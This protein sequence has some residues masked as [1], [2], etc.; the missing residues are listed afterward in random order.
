MK[1]VQEKSIEIDDGVERGELLRD[2]DM[3][4]AFKFELA[5]KTNHYQR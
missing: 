5:A 3:M 4:L 2:R 1:L